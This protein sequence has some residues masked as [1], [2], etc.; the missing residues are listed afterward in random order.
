MKKYILF[1]LIPLC[2]LLSAQTSLSGKVTEA[3]SGAPILFGSIALFKSGNLITGT[4]TDLN[5]NYHFSNIEPG[6]YDVE[7]SYVGC[8]T[9]RI[10]GVIIYAGKENK[11]DIKMESPGGVNLEEV[12]VTSYKVPLIAR[13]NTTCG[14]TVTINQK[15]HLPTRNI[16][17]MPAITAGLSSGDEGDDVYV[18][19]SRS[20]QS[21][22]PNTPDNLNESDENNYSQFIENQFIEADTE[23]FST[24]GIDVDKASYSLVRR[25]LLQQNTLPPADAVRIEEL[26]NYFPYNYPPPTGTTPFSIH[27]KMVNCPWNPETALLHIGMKGSVM[28]LENAPPSNLVFLIDVSGSM[29][30][31]DKLGLLMDA[32]F[33]LTDQLRA[34]EKISSATYAGREGLLPPAT[35]GS[36]KEKIK[37]AIQSLQAGGGTAGEA[38]IQ[39]AYKIAAENY[40]QNGNNRVIL[41]TDGD[42]NVGISDLKE[43]EK[44]IE[45]K[46]KTGIFL[47]TLGFGFGNYKDDIMETLADKGNGNYAYLDNINEAKKVLGTELTGTLFTIAKDVKIQIEF[48]PEWVE[49]Y[50]LIG[51]E[52]RLLAK[53][54]FHDDTKDAGELGAGH[55]VTALYEVKLKKRTDEEV[56][57]IR[58]RY[59]MPEEDQSR[60]LETFV[61]GE[62]EIFE[63]AP[64]NVRFAASVA[65][66]GLFLRDSKYKGS[67]TFDMVE[68]MTEASR[69]IDPFDYKKEFLEM[70]QAAKILGENL[71]KK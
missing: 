33:I 63:N 42:F 31:P 6:T 59:K 3:E 7:A 70:V 67:L 58:L 55:T 60:W 13:D 17:S 14:Q 30:S 21:F 1:I 45:E 20:E 62:T 26:I 56:L 35:S 51:Y 15:W 32:F 16:N 34:E 64:E 68:K 4:D 54:D 29:S 47:T 49:N 23:A 11:L 43:L 57:K 9:Q 36:E 5:G 69:K 46:R 28:A 27:T 66:F 2:Q 50:R 53:E 12:V 24:F 19:G 25:M 8:Q 10:N 38:G 71:A 40:Q 41:A 39:L 52:N 18:R 65:G 37:N 22:N 61:T 48:D 44:L